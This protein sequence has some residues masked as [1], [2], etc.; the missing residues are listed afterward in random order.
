MKTISYFLIVSILLIA[1]NFIFSQTFVYVSPKNS[2]ILVSLNTNI[3]LKSSEYI[4][5]SSLSQNEFSISGSVS[6]E[7]QGSVK[8]SDD[9]KTVLFIP[10]T[11]FAANE[12]VSVNVVPG[13]RTSGGA[14]LPGVAI[15]FKTTPLTQKININ[16][17]TLMENESLNKPST[18]FQLYKSKTKISP[19]AAL[20]TNFPAVTID[21]SNNPSNGKIFITN[22]ALTPDS[23]GN[24]LMILNNDGSVA[25][26]KQLSEPSFNFQVLPNGELSY[27]N[28]IVNYGD[29]GDVKW[30]VTDTSLTPVDSFQCGNGY[31]ADLHDF[32]LLPNGHAILF[33]YDPEPFDMSPYGGNPNA[34]VIGAVIQE[35]DASKN[36]VFQWRTWDYLPITDS[37]ID[38]T[39]STV[40][41]IHANAFDVDANGNILLS[42]R[43][44]S[45]IIKIDRQTGNIDWILGGKQNQFT[46]INENPSNS[47][48]YFSFQH[49]V[50]IQPN[51]DITLFDNGNQHS[52][53]YSRG[54]E[55]TLD[56]QNMTATLVWEYRHTPD[57]YAYAMGTVQ[58]LT[59]GNTIIGWGIASSAGAP[60]LTEIKPDNTTA[61]E[62]SLP[63]GQMSYRSYK[64][65]WT[66]EIPEAKVTPVGGILQGN[67]YK[68][69]TPN[70]TTG[71]T[72]TFD[73]LHTALYA[74]ATVTSFNYAPINPLFTTTAPLLVSNY[75]NIQGEGI[76]SYWGK[77]QVNLY[78]FPAVTNPKATIVYA[79]S[80]ID[81]NFIPMPTSYDSTTGELTFTT[82]TLGD[83]AFGVPQT[84]DSA[85]VPVPISPADSGIVNE[86]APVKLVWGTR[87]IIQTYHLQVSAS[88][89]F[90]N[91]IVDNSELNSTSY[92]LGTVNNN[93]TY[94]WRIN[95]TN[96]AGTSSWSNAEIFNTAP[97]FIKMLTPIGGEKFYTDSTYII[98]WESNISDTVNITLLNGNNIASVIGDSVV[99]GTNAFLWLVSHNLK[100]DSSYK[101]MVASISNSNLFG[102][103]NSN[104]LIQPS[105]TTAVTGLP[106]TVKSFE[107]SQNYPNPFNPSTIIQYSIPQESHV[108]IDI[109]NVI[110]QKITTL[111]NSMQNSGNYSVTW[112]ASKLASGVYFYSIKASGNT[113]QN[114]FAVKKLMLLK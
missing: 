14:T 54:V 60:I 1:N 91:L 34:T 105:N 7:H 40:D 52:P 25:K 16:P 99:G 76:N 53:E 84:I 74:N 42:M 13:I 68:F 23:I 15:H 50:K 104:F 51:G 27:A 22:F 2:S 73:T 88:S 33:A 45:S 59:N 9:D 70:D 86:S 19:T 6:G 94:Y 78:N 98:R 28:V 83:F 100:Q 21:S 106:N 58:K 56:E 112:D 10:A 71:I 24:F 32:L 3:I 38:P 79:R 37:Y 108:R 93:S 49:N 47:P 30:M 63:A 39:T 62:I 64:F 67:T 82:S 111:V 36:V 113:G 46:F 107:L 101:I 61:L 41:L 110:G 89:S 65:P 102:L 75:F 20:P 66:S 26:Y 87:G 12:N 57:I 48:N 80:S 31:N 17:L 8:L 29:Y 92:T 77:V 114:Y 90:T 72:I 35:I 69:N 81:S 44:L 96:A 97:P 43:H 95:N 18:L 109:Y 11:P 55:Y 4:D 85:Y 5:P 103:S